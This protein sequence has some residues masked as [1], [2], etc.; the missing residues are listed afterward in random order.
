VVWL[1]LSV[2]LQ[3]ATPDDSQ[4]DLSLNVDRHLQRFVLCSC[5]L[6]A[7]LFDACVVEL[8]GRTQGLLFW[9]KMCFLNRVF[10]T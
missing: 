10:V 8:A 1:Q 9:V 2:V 6:L 7:V 5:I 4:I 3:T